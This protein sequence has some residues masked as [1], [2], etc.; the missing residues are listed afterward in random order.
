MQIQQFSK[1]QKYYSYTKFNS[2]FANSYFLLYFFNS[3]L[4][5]YIVHGNVV[6]S[7]NELLLWDIHV[8]LIANA[9]S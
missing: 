9:F 8:I 5:V 4:T 1:A 3:A 2:S 6:E 7:T